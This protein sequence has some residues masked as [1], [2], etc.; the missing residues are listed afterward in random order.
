M[1]LLLVFIFIL[2]SAFFNG[3]ETAFI[4]INRIKLHSRLEERNRNAKILNKL[5]KNS[6]NVISTFLLGTNIFDVAVVIYFTNFMTKVLGNNPLIPIYVTLILTPVILI[7]ATLIPKVIFREFADGIMF[8]LAPFYN[9]IYIILYP[10]QFVFV[11]SIKAILW[12]LGFKKKKNLYTKDDFNILLGMTADKGLL[13]ENEKKFIESIMNFR[14]I[15]AKEIMVPLVRMTCVEENDTVEIASALMLTTHH[16]R[17]P[18]FRMRVDNMIGYVEN[19]DLLEANKHDKIIKYLKETIFVPDLMPIN[20]VLVRMQNKMA[21]MAFV[22]DEYGGVA[23]AITNQDII[24]EIIGEFVEI[25]DEWIKKEGD[26]YFVNGMAN[27]DE[28]N[29]ELNLKIKKMDFETVAGF[30][31][32]RM[33][34]IPEAGDSFDEGKYTFEVASASNVRVKRV[35]ISPKRKKEKKKGVPVHGNRPD[36]V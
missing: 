5:I 14:N 31:L 16:S 20:G 30:V 32:Y 10:V 18:V 34:K 29:E 12:V 2:L 19:K 13:K 22:V 11:R 9:I 21:Q 27:V 35:K 24:A 4:S 23:G 3:S 36:P 7:A 8:A 15:K 26:S 33:G 6:E 25:R 1:E 28:L 17:I